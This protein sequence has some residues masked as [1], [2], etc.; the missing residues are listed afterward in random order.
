[1][2]AW[3]HPLFSAIV[4]ESYK[5]KLL[6]LSSGSD[7]YEEREVAG[8][9]E[10]ALSAASC[11]SCATAQGQSHQHLRK[12]FLEI[13]VINYLRYFGKPVTIFKIITIEIQEFLQIQ[14]YFKFKMNFK[15]I[16]IE[17]QEYELN[18]ATE[19]Y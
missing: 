16:T 3:P 7:E 10:A 14:D 17:N 4:A 8:P 19:I 13:F 6:S 1:M 11:A 5:E 15:I 12:I 9:S 2:C 18:Q